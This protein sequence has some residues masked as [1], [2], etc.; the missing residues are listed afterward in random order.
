[1]IG[2]WEKL[3]FTDQFSFKLLYLIILLRDFVM[4]NSL[5]AENWPA[6]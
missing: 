3:L 1:M 4:D 6:V 2:M 5:I